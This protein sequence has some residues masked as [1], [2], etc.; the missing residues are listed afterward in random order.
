MSSDTPS[1]SPLP[2]DLVSLK[3]A[4]QR[5]DRAPSTLRDW[6]R[7]GELKAYHGEGTHP[8][9]RPTLVSVAELLSLVVVT[10]KVATPGR[11]PPVTDEDLEDLRTKL[12][13][14]EAEIRSLQSTVE[15]ERRTAEV[16]THA[17][18]IMEQF[19]GD[20]RMSLERER[21]RADGAEAELRAL[22]AVGSL[23]WWRKLLPGP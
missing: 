19:S 12:A 22:R 17:L 6:I 23:P 15:S 4:A 10:G 13:H 16:A 2:V 18:K 7:S 20:L 8:K 11:R 21:A 1:A 9:N 3:E 14:A 5:V